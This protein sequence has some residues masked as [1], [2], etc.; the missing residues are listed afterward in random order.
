M[1]L[2]ANLVM[3]SKGGPQDARFAPMAMGTADPGAAL[4]RSLGG[5]VHYR[6]AAG[7]PSPRDPH[8]RRSVRPYRLSGGAAGEPRPALY[9]APPRTR[10]EH[11]APGSRSCA[12]PRA[13]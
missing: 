1:T 2:P 11:P 12:E 3:E 6:P 9:R 4:S 7:D 13:H 10:A 8:R 5:G